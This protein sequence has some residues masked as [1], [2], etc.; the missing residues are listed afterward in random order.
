MLECCESHIQHHTNQSKHFLVCEK[1]KLQLS[2]DALACIL[3]YKLDWI[4]RHQGNLRTELYAGLQDAIERGDTRADEVGRRI[5]LP[6]SFTDNL[7]YKHKT[8]KM[9]WQ[10]VVSW[11][12]RQIC[13]IHVQRSLAGD[14]VYATGSRPS[15]IRKTGFC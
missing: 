1:L 12:C 15:C 4:K 9:L 6:S 2:V 8:T 10:Y 11:I 14:T 5:L 13:D 3:Q 7:R